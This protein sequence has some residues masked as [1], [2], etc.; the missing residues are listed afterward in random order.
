MKVLDVNV[1]LAAYRDDHP[2]HATAKNYLDRLFDSG[3]QFGVPWVVWWG[4]LR[5]VSHPKVFEVPSSPSEA[6]M[7]VDA[8]RAQPGHV[9]CEP[10]PAHTTLLGQAITDGD[11][12]ANLLPDALLVAL[13]AEHGA[14]V[15]SFDRDFAR[16]GSHIWNRPN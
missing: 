7:F 15:T 13:A 2:H 8:L 6:L 16:F 9:P 5:I 12:A 4:F 14:Q 10:G 1:V 11:A 3:E